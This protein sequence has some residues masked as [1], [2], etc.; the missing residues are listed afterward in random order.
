MSHFVYSFICPIIIQSGLILNK[1]T[2]RG[3]F[4]CFQNKYYYEHV[5][6][7]Y[8]TV[9]AERHN[10]IHTSLFFLLLGSTFKSLFDRATFLNF[11][12]II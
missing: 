2:T 8:I 10:R 12:D 9:T 6:V 7:K 11:E 1:Y 3:Y 5:V 4:S